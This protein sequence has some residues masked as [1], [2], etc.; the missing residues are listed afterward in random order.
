M[1][2]QPGQAADVDNEEADFLAALV[3]A[4][5]RRLKPER[6]EALKAAGGDTALRLA[7]LLRLATTVERGRDPK[8][9]RG[10]FELTAAGPVLELRVPEGW[11]AKHPMTAADL[12]KQQEYLA[13]AGIHFTV[14]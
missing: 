12:R 1:G 2:D 9:K 5:R 13:V 10:A 6:I 14:P 7:A 11:L 3:G 4:H 8:A